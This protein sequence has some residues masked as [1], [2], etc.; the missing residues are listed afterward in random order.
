M[1][2]DKSLAAR[3][4]I[5]T[6]SN[7]LSR[8]ICL[9]QL[10]GASSCSQD[11]SISSLNIFPLLI[12]APL[13]L[14]VCV[15]VPLCVQAHV[16]M[17]GEVSDLRHVPSLVPLHFIVLTQGFSVNLELANSARLAGQQP[18]GTASLLLLSATIPDLWASSFVRCCCFFCS[19]FTLVLG[20]KSGSSSSF[21]E[22]L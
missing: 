10:A 21:N 1:S 9:V 20:I 6:D 7:L 4:C 16:C 2:F 5:S 13:S 14:W 11:G 3:A 12:L 15:Y 8:S 18:Q 17:H 22:P 19:D